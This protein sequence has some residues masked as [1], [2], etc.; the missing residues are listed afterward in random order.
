MAAG[1][2]RRP[3]LLLPLVRL[4]HLAESAIERVLA[5]SSLK[6]EDWRVLDELAGRRTV[7]MSDLAQA[8]LITG[9]TLTR[10]VDRLVSQ[11]II[12][13]TADLH[14]RR[15]VLVALTPRGRTLR[16]RLVDAVAEAECAAFESCGLDVDQLR[17]LVDTTSNLTS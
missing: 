7:P 4:T 11:G 10:T 5:D 17:E 12:Y 6:I 1:Q 8:T 9:P 13:R 16:N 14:D 3:N 2:Q 15:R